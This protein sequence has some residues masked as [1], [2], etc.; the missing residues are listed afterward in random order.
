MSRV[1]KGTLGVAAVAI[2]G[3][4]LFRAADA[5]YFQ[6]RAELLQD[7]QT[8]TGA[9]ASRNDAL[10]QAQRIAAELGALADQ[11]LGSDAESVDHMLRSRLNAIVL[12]LGLSKATVGTGKRTS[13]TTPARKRFA[14]RSRA[15]TEARER[16]DFVEV[17]AWVDGEGTLAHAFELID[18][19][20]AEPWMKKLTAVRFEPRNNGERFGINVKL[21]TVFLPGRAPDPQRLAEH[22]YDRSSLDRYAGVIQLNPFRL[23]PPRQADA[24]SVVVAQ[25]D[26]P[27]PP[28]FPYE[29]WL[30]TGVA[31]NAAG[32]EAWLRNQGSGETRRLGPGEGLHEVQFVNARGDAAEFEQNGRRFI[33]ALGDPMDKRTP[34]N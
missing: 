15:A 2:V 22:T 5:G 20:E 19:L 29:R 32:A 3:F 7:I 4:L 18:R 28:P 33:V 9:L 24:P 12:E 21:T 17:E 23:P 27:A 10:S 1:A 6:P 11:T 14:G 13:R 26:P 34:I 31:Q 25:Q 8:R 30:L 16:I